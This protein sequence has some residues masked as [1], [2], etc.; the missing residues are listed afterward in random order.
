[1]TDVDFSAYGHSLGP[2]SLSATGGDVEY[3]GIGGTGA[4]TMW[5]LSGM[6]DFRGFDAN[7]RP[8]FQ[9]K[10]SEA[11]VPLPAAAWMM[12]SGLAAVGG[13]TY[14]RPQKVAAA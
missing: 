13:L 1:L 6:A 10:P 3:S 2:V 5:A 4:P 7:S 8:A 9:I 12:I 14:R 11:V